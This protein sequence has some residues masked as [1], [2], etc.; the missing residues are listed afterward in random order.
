MEYQYVVYEGA[1]REEPL[2]LFSKDIDFDDFYFDSIFSND[3]AASFDLGLPKTTEPLQTTSRSPS[4][5]PLGSPWSFST[6][7]PSD[8]E[9]DAST[10]PAAPYGNVSAMTSTAPSSFSQEK[11]QAPQAL[12]QGARLSRP[13]TGV[14]P[15]P[16]RA[17]GRHASRSPAPQTHPDTLCVAPRS[18]RLSTISRAL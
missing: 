17:C 10:E 5:A 7:S 15:Q 8:S 9:A 4:P 11:Q 18:L 1:E 14:T 2:E 3:A 6:H 13:C 16:E 12:D